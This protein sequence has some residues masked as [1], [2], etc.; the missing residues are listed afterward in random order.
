MV[1]VLHAFGSFSYRC[2]TLT[3]GWAL[4]S[5]EVRLESWLLLFKCQRR[6]HRRLVRVIVISDFAKSIRDRSE[7]TVAFIH[8]WGSAIN[9]LK[10]VNTKAIVSIAEEWSMLS[11]SLDMITSRGFV[12]MVLRTRANWRCYMTTTEE[13]NPR[14]V[15]I[16]AFGL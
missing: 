13:W 11:W 3:L 12:V 10:T 5:N 16:I 1:Q 7:V 6:N 14:C 8:H 4:T 2:I 15:H 9:V